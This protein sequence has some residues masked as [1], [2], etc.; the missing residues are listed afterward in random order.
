M[1]DRAPTVAI[2]EDNPS[3]LRSI[4]RLLN[5]EGF[6]VEGFSSA[7]AFL[8]SE[9]ARRAVCVVLDIHLPGM[10]GLELRRRLAAGGSRVPIIFITAISDEALKSTAT[11]LGCVAYFNKPFA[12]EALVAAVADAV[13][14]AKHS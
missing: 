5:A 11:Q 2:V 9:S 14:A 6:S 13:A 12:P 10:S 4:Q 1:D 3:M 7:E 8:E